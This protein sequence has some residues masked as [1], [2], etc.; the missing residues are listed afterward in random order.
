MK[1]KTI[2]ADPPWPEYGS[3]KS[4]RGADRHYPLMKV[5]EI[6]DLMKKE[7]LGKIDFSG[8][9]FY[10]WVT[11]N[12]LPDGLEILNYLGYRY[13][14]NIV[15]VKPSFGLGQ[16]FRGQHELCL[17]GVIG[18][19]PIKSRNVASVIKEKKRRHSE[20]PKKIYSIIEAVSYPPRLEMFAREKLEGWD[21]WGNEIVTTE[22]RILRA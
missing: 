18:K 7:L 11:N 2:L 17:F 5:R 10:L 6:K 15:W 3:G 8:S 21:I 4:K 20:K 1:Y 22:Q 16:Y 14:T 19:L 9:H 12:Y 13:V